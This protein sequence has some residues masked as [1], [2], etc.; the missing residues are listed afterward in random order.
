ML[1]GCIFQSWLVLCLH[2]HICTYHQKQDIKKTKR[3]LFKYVSPFLHENP[4]FH[5][6]EGRLFYKTFFARHYPKCTNSA[7]PWISEISQKLGFSEQGLLLV[8]SLSWELPT[9][10]ASEI[11]GPVLPGDKKLI[12]FPWRPV[13]TTAFSTWSSAYGAKRET[14]LLQ[15]L[16]I[17][18]KNSHNSSVECKN[19]CERSI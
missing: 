9:L 2:T 13:C 16:K 8:K 5:K 7:P 1:F 17:M 4:C 6:C 14:H 19:I 18:N 11:L 10:S 15:C 3:L 12:C